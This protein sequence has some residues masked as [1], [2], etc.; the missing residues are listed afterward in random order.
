MNELE[1]TLN[2]KIAI[3]QQAVALLESVDNQQHEIVQQPVAQLEDE[4]FLQSV[5]SRISWSHHIILLDK[6]KSVGQR[7]WY[8]L[9]SFEH[10]SSRNVLA[11]Q[12][13]SGLFE[14]Q[15]IILNTFFLLA[16]AYYLRF[17]IRNK[18][19]FTKSFLFLFKNITIL[20][21]SFITLIKK[22]DILF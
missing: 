20:I 11:M 1:A 3:V 17:I 5:V 2:N 10:G 7:F 6:V 22:Q 21:K 12:I 8:M 4:T 9:N 15:I 14:R 13:E 18:V 16:L 19:Y